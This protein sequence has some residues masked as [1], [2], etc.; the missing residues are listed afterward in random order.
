MQRV[1]GEY[2]QLVYLCEKARG[3]GCQVVESISPRIASIRNWLSKELARSLLDALDE[4]EQRQVLKTYESIEGWEEAEEVIRQKFREFCQKVGHPKDLADQTIT[5]AAMIVDSVP[6]TPSTSTNPFDLL[7]PS[8]LAT[9]YNQVL[10]EVASYRPL[11]SNA[12]FDFFAGCLWPE[13]ATA[14]I[15]NLG[16]TIFAAG[17]PDDLHK[18]SH[19]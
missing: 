13:I 7:D 18:V 11:L 1:A 17:R 14:I 19:A 5:P 8:P 9:V 12:G 3:Q 16:S 6:K 2:S 4:K 10:G 15:D